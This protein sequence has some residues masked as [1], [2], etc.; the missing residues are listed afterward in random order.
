M[1]SKLGWKL[2]PWIETNLICKLTLHRN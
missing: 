2:K 1:E